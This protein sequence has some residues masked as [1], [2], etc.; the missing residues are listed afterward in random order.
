MRILNKG[1][2][3]LFFLLITCV[4]I[5]IYFLIEKLPGSLV[6][7]FIKK[8]H[9]LHFNNNRFLTFRQSAI[10]SI[11]KILRYRERNSNRLSTCLSR[12]IVGS[13]FLHLIGIDNFIYLAMNVNAY[14]KKE[15]HAWLSDAN[16]NLNY[17]TAVPTINILLKL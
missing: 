6:L 13:L 11:V 4:D 8:R 12:S 3:V 5:L 7:K 2:Y 10:R 15:A 1:I 14:G 16:T 17:T 9:F